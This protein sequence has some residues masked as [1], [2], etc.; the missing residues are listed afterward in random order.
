MRTKRIGGAVTF[1]LGTL[2]LIIGIYGK[3]QLAKAQL[4]IDKGEN[5]FSGNRYGK[6]VG[7]AL[8][9]H[10]AKYRMPLMICLTGGVVLVMVGVGI[11]LLNRKK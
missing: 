1:I 11:L 8:E 4:G 7:E 6:F 2:L 10:L 3:H 9:G 5:L